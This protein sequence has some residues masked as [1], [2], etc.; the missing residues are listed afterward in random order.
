MVRSVAN[1]LGEVL[2]TLCSLRT[3]AQELKEVCMM[4]L[5]GITG[6]LFPKPS[7]MLR[8]PAKLC[9]WGSDEVGG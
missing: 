1:S 7:A 6:L 5:P 8:V 9:K 4:V 2:Q 3:P